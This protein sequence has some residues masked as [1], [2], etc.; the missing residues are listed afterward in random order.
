MVVA[1]ARSF[2]VVAVAVMVSAPLDTDTETVDE[3]NVL[4][5]VDAC[6]TKVSNFTML[7]VL[8]YI[9]QLLKS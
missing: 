1:V 9:R 4:T 7:F 5:I 8:I 6:H 3:I 2:V